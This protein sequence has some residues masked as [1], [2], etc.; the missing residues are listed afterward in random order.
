MITIFH[1]DDRLKAQT[2]A[3]R[4]LGK[5]YEVI[6]GETLTLGD[7]ASVFLGTSLF[8]EQRKILIKDLSENSECFNKLADYLNT[9]HD[10]VIWESKLDKR[11]ALY[12]ELT[13]KNVEVREFKNIEPPEKKLVFD[14]FDLAWRSDG[15]QAIR[16][17]EKIE[18]T[19]D[20]Y[21]FF[22]LMASQAFKKLEAGQ[23]KAAKV[24]KLMAKTDLD[25]KT[26]SLNSW[27]LI[28]S[29][30]LRIAQ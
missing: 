7:L 4:L 12:K 17:C 1:G 11:T 24:L 14:V 21:M 16:L 8:V 2:E 13:A 15:Q 25:M 5:G 18:A 9:P 20:P 29:L 10:I 26:T 27:L 22:G 6:E 30:L 23:P 28:K 19:N 3:E